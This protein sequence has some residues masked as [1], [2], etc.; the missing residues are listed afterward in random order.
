[1]QSLTPSSR[2]L[3][4]HLASSAAPLGMS[5]TSCV[6]PV[7]DAGCL[8]E[9]D[10]WLARQPV[11]ESMHGRVIRLEGYRGLFNPL[12][13]LSDE[14]L[15]GRMTSDEWCTLIHQL[16]RAALGG[17]LVKKGGEVSLAMMAKRSSPHAAERFLD[18]EAPT[19]LETRGVKFEWRY[20][21]ADLEPGSNVY[22]YAAILGAR[23]PAGQPASQ[24][25]ASAPPS[26]SNSSPEGQPGGQ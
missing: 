4:W 18:Q 21:N 23:R 20:T 16:N 2:V 14:W 13:L 11:A 1:M 12:P 15:E 26:E 24:A 5:S 6:L 7:D 3:V 9:V 10:Q 25:S 17:L 22:L 8:S 19:W